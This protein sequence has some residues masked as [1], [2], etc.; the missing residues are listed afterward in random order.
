MSEQQPASGCRASPGG[1]QQPSASRQPISHRNASVKEGIN[2]SRQALHHGINLSSCTEEQQDTPRL[3][4]PVKD[5]SDA[6]SMHKAHNT[7][8]Q[9]DAGSAQK[10]GPNFEKLLA[11]FHERS[12]KA[13]SRSDSTSRT[14]SNPVFAGPACLSE[15]VHALQARTAEAAQSSSCLSERTMESTAASRHP[16]TCA[17]PSMSV[18]PKQKV[19]CA[20]QVTAG[21][22]QHV[23][24]AGLDDSAQGSGASMSEENCRQE[25]SFREQEHCERSTGPPQKAHALIAAQGHPKAKLWP[26]GQ[27]TEVGRVSV[28]VGQSTPRHA[29]ACSKAA[30]VHERQVL[31]ACPV[32]PADIFAEAADLV[33]PT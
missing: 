19:P 33:C 31:A 15:T 20:D 2:S 12:A 26:S 6:H 11:S 28:S 4:A 21:R 10:L 3:G 1:A 17:M 24:H 16:G 13:H 29:R 14:Y 25:S 30:Q 7:A 9:R 8:R 22:M 27:A 23:Q 18:H 32:T 5:A